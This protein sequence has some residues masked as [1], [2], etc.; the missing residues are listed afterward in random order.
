MIINYT[1]ERTDPVAVAGRT[2][3]PE[4]YGEFGTSGLPAHP[5]RRPQAGTGRTK[6]APNRTGALDRTSDSEASRRSGPAQ[7]PAAPLTSSPAGP[8][9]VPWT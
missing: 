6:N 9:P 7:P 4:L 5:A 1:G 3:G 2:L 8:T